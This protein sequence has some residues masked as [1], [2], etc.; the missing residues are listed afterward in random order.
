MSQRIGRF[1]N[2]G[3]SWLQ[4][5]HWRFGRRR[6]P[7]PAVYLG[8]P[9]HCQG[10][11]LD[12]DRKLNGPSVRITLSQ[13]IVGLYN[14][15]ALAIVADSH[16]QYFK[17]WRDL[18]PVL[19]SAHVYRLYGSTLAVVR[20]SGLS[21]RLLT[22]AGRRRSQMSSNWA[23]SRLRQDWSSMT[24]PAGRSFSA[25]RKVSPFLALSDSAFG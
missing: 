25:S 21:T 12:E 18:W 6:V 7:Y 23:K 22:S 17:L 8:Q 2:L 15:H 10:V 11:C 3:G 1:E 9:I 4:I 16:Q 14:R 20:L 24:E 19:G 13:A 5:W